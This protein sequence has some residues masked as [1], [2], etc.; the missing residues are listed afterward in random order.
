MKIL[1]T[2]NGTEYVNKE[3][4]TY[5]KGSGINHQLI[6]RYTSKQ[7]GV[8]ERKNMTLEKAKSMLF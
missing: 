3:F 6:I 5:L 2:H 1:R 8:A 7:N 4:K